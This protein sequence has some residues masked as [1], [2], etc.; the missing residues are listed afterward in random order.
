MVAKDQTDPTELKYGKVFF[1]PYTAA[2]TIPSGA[3]MWFD[4]LIMSTQPIA[5][6]GAG[7]GT[8][9]APTTIRLSGGY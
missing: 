9:A 4:E 3:T 6:P 7:G 8:V 2:A 5:D 1:A